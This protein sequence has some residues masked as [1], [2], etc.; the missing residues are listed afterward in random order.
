MT[1]AEIRTLV[2]SYLNRS[3]ATDALID[4]FMVLGLRK[5]NRKL[6]PW[7]IP[8][9]RT[10][11]TYTITDSPAS[12]VS[13]PSDFLSFDQLTVDDVPLTPVSIDEFRRRAYADGT[14]S[15]FTRD[16]AEYLIAGKVPVSSVVQLRYFGS[17]QDLTADTDTNALTLFAPDVLMYAALEQAGIHFEHEDT[18]IWK[19]EFGE[20]LNDIIE[21][22]QALTESEGSMEV[23]PLYTE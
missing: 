11:I 6:T 17:F 4:S 16:D 3:D 22:A 2:V 19:G 8:A 15:V 7:R 23:V 12:S 21:Q 13:I 14:C 10:K 20:G 18:P 1:K 5:I 9:M